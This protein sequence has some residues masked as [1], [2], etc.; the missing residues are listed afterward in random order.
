MRRF[1]HV[2]CFVIYCFSV[3]MLAIGY[4][5]SSDNSFIFVGLYD[6]ISMFLSMFFY[7]MLN[8]KLVE[9]FTLRLIIKFPLFVLLFLFLRVNLYGYLFDDAYVLPFQRHVIIFF[10]ILYVFEIKYII[11]KLNERKT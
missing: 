6:V 5:G 1:F 11:S 4:Y 8:R 9:R 3:F 7:F 2:F 10:S